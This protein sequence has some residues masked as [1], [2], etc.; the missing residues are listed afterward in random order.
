M[1]ALPLAVVLSLAASCQSVVAPATIAGIA[2]HESGLDPAAI[3]YNGN[4][5]VDAGLMQIN[6]AN[7]AWLGLDMRTSMDP[8]RSIGAAAQVLVSFS[9]YNT[10]SPTAGI[11]N[12]YASAITASIQA[13]N[14]QKPSSRQVAEAVPPEI[15]ARP[16]NGRELIYEPTH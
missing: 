12:G 9:R 8:C 5:T 2:K 4:G 10:G 15:F 3:H 6:S 13:V 14:G 11:A 16:S 7:F 1:A